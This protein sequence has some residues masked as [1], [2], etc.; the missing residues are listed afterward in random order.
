MSE[1]AQ[2]L[3]RTAHVPQGPEMTMNQ[4]PHVSVVMPAYRAAETLKVAAGSV[5]C[6]DIAALELLIVDDGSPDLTAAVADEIAAGDKRVRVIRQS[7]A[8]PSAAR[9][10]GIAEARAPL[11]AFLDA[12][13]RWQPSCLTAH[14][15][16]F[17]ADPALGISFARVRFCDPQLR[18]TSVVSASH[19]A[20]RLADVLGENPA[21]TTSS[22]VV[23]RPVLEAA[24]IFDTSLTHA[25]DQEFLARVIATTDWRVSGLDSVLVDYRTSPNGLSSDLSAMETGWHRLMDSIRTRAPGPLAAAEPQARALFYRYLARRALRVGAPPRIALAALR[26]AGRASTRTLLTHQPRRT[27]LTLVGTLA[28]LLPGNPAARLFSR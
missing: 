20:L 26:T 5:L 21:C 19:G 28:A 3:K 15:A 17:A 6:Q 14:L 2:R 1:L 10:R 4:L 27:A 23:R 16:A 11:I 22:I 24:G 9:N 13:D 7:N 18:P 25:E 12:D 8:G